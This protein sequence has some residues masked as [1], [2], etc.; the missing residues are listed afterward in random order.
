MTALALDPVLR[1]TLRA[2]LSVLFV[3]SACHKLRDVA[4]F[5]TALANYQLVP[6]RWIR[7]SAKLCIAI[8]LCIALALWVPEFSAFAAYTAAG[9]L[10]IYTSA[11]GINLLRGRRGIDCGCGG[12]A[13]HQP[14]SAALV[15]RNAVVSAAALA[16]A[17]PATSRL[18][19]WVDGM[20]IFAAVVALALL[21]AAV[22]GLLVN[23]PGMRALGYRSRAT[24]HA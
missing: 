15:V 23:A 3:W 8:E 2:A 19:M 12:F 24:T 16:S 5:R 17:L 21:Y 7:S 11:I 1:L 14:L 10:T 9:L 20:T 18:L 4:A 13:R 22:D 6:D